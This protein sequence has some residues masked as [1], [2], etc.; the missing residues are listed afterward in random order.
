M[1]VP[2]LLSVT[3]RRLGVEEIAALASASGLSAV[4]WSGD[5]HVPP[6][7]DAAADRAVKAAAD[8]GLVMTGYGSYHWAGDD[9]ASAFEPVLET[10]LR[11]GAPSVRI[12]AGRSASSDA[13]PEHRARVIDGITAAVERAAAVGVTVALEFHGGTL[14]DT[15]QGAAALCA[16]TGA[17]SHWQPPVGDSD[18]DAL[19]GLDVVLPHV[20]A[21]HVFAWGPSGARH[22]LARRQALWQRALARVATVPGDHPV[23]LEFVSDD[24]PAN[25]HRDAATLLD[26]LSA[27]QK[28]P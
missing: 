9:P 3:F 28:G 12:W 26:L 24:D 13:T 2:G 19:R 15:A 25:L 5:V 20:C 16:A 17:R 1:L 10:A 6:G 21:A 23:L 4:E 11:L 8:S 7:D 27:D 18:E 22:P 14:T